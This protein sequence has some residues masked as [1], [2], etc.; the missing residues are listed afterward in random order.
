MNS[1]IRN[2]ARPGSDPGQTYHQPV[3]S[4]KLARLQGLLPQLA[5]VAGGS[6]EPSLPDGAWVVARPVRSGDPK[7]GQVVVVEH[8]YR[9][10]FE[11][12]KRVSA[13]SR[14]RGLLWIAGDN[15]LQSTDSEEFGALP[16]LRLRAVVV[17]RIRPWP[18]LWLG[19]DSRHLG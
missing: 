18:W 2:F 4:G 6:M 14:E 3:L 8:P 15:R 16:L 19:A 10:G 1:L 9:P 5:M 12:I 17:M 13:V 11:L 7:L